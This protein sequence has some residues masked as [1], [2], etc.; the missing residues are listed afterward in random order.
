M[1]IDIVLGRPEQE[2]VETE[3]YEDFA[4]DLASRLEGSF[5][6][7]REHLNTAAGRRK[8]TYDLRVRPQSFKVGQFVWYYYPRKYVGR[9]PKWQRCYTGPYLVVRTIPPANYV[10]QRSKGS[11]MKVVHGDKLKSWN[12]EALISWLKDVPGEGETE[13]NRLYYRLGWTKGWYK[14]A[15]RDKRFGEL[16]LDGQTCDWKAAKAKLLELARKYDRAA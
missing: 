1:P 11:Q 8:V 3:S 2:K 15:L 6:L 4:D 10:I 12:G 14:G 9:T 16:S 13:L 7:A 5:E